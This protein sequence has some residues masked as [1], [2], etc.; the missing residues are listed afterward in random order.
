[1]AK[2]MKCAA[3]GEEAMEPMGMM[4]EGAAEPKKP[5]NPMMGAKKPAAKKSLGLDST[6]KL[7]AFAKMKFGKK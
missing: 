4:D 2:K 7:R 6:D 3:C 1:M 5:A